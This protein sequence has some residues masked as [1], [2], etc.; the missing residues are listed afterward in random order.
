[1]HISENPLLIKVNE[2]LADLLRQVADT[3][4]TINMLY[5]LAGETPPF[6]QEELGVSATEA[7]NNGL[8]T[9]RPDE[10]FGKRMGDAVEMVLKRY[11]AMGKVPVEFDTIFNCLKEGGFG[12]SS[13]DE[14]NARNGVS[15]VLSKNPDFIRLPNGGW[16]LQEWYPNAIK[17]KKAKKYGQE[18]ES[19]DPVEAEKQS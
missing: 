1:M 3:K 4:K 9:L 5:E 19:A 7:G 16:G 6:G 10:Y 17:E 13:P 2:K 14:K 8:K 18:V 12:F 15:V 11:K